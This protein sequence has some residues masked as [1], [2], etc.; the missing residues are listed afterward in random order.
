MIISDAKLDE[1]IQIYSALSAD[2][3]MPK[4]VHLSHHTILSTLEEL[5]AHRAARA[6]QT[7]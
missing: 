6:V 2:K 5:K 4:A 3:Y 7:T 1:L